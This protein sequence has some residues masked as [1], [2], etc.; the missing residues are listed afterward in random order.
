MKKPELSEGGSLLF[1]AG[2][3]LAILLTPGC[4]TREAEQIAFSSAPVLASASQFGVTVSSLQSRPYAVGDL[5][6][7]TFGAVEPVLPPHEE[8]VKGDG[9][10][11]LPLIG[12]IV[13]TNMTVS[14]LKRELLTRYRPCFP[15]N[16]SLFIPPPEGVYSVRGEVKS[17]GLKQWGGELT[18]TQLIESAG[19]F[20]HRARTTHVQLIRSDGTKITV[21][22]KKAMKHP[23]FDPKVLP[24]DMILVPR[25]WW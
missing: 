16:W 10:I 15:R 22:C 7:V 6:V 19:G 14:D 4:A 17:P 23:E 21:D 12:S 5:V 2:L 8:R 24:G 18:V 13:V 11:T 3:G 25:R 1:W 20:T 9:T